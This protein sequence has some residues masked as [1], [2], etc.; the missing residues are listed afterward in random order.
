CAGLAYTVSGGLAAYAPTATVVSAPG[1]WTCT[2]GGSVYS[3]ATASVSATGPFP[4]SPT[5]SVTAADLANASTPALASNTANF[6]LTVNGPLTL[7]APT[8][9]ATGVSGR[10]YGQG[11]SCAPTAACAALPY[12]VS[13]GLGG[14]VANATIVSAPGTW[15]C[16]LASTTY[17]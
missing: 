9:A 7:T 15:S 14:Y 17:N 13:G 11:S 8:T 12:T 6:A 3:C 1:T 10:S 4:V 2:L 5:V 16:S